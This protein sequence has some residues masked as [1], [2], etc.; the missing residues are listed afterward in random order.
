MGAESFY[1]KLFV[2]KA[3]GTNSSLPHFLSKL[4]DLNIK[5]RSRGTNEFELNDFLIMTLHLKN[6]EIAEISIE[7]C[8]SWFEDCVLEVYKLSQVIHNQIFCLNLINSNGEDVS[9]QN[10]IDF[11]N[12]I[13][14]IYL[15]KYNDFIARFGVSNVKCLPKDEFYRYIKR[16]KNKSVIKRIFTK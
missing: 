2:S 7:G 13:Q 10:Q 4:T 14:E 11:Y 16:I 12:A 3:E 8:F 1:I 5:C 6:D 15:E 9:F